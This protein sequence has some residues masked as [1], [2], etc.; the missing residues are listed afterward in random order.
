[1][2]RGRLEEAKVPGEA[3]GNGGKEPRCQFVSRL[4]NAIATSAS[5]DNVLQREFVR[6]HSVTMNSMPVPPINAK[7]FE[8]Q[9][10]SAFWEYYVP[11]K[12]SA[13]AGSPCAWL[14]QSIYLP[15]PPPAL[16]FSLIAVAMTRLGWLH[17][18]DATVRA[19]RIVYG[20]ALI[21]LQKALY[22]KRL[23]C[24]D[25]TLAAC[26]VLALYE[27]G[28]FSTSILRFPDYSYA[29]F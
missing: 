2:K 1:M 22:D 25:E 24:Q 26:N 7:I 29:A 20:C 17:E 9:L 10:I 16:R 23:M 14:Q 21:E 12:S 5:S 18:D 15:N 3:S 6:R 19:G 11:S 13:Q 4:S 28:K 27:V 8:A